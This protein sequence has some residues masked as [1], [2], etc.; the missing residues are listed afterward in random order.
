M[1]SRQK[2]KKL[3]RKRKTKWIKRFLI[4]A[5]LSLSLI[6]G[7]VFFQYQKGVKQAGGA[8]ISTEEVAEFNGIKDEQGR[9]N[10]LLLG[11]DTRGEEKSRTDTIM[12]AQYDPKNEK[13]RLVSLMRDI[14][15]DIP[16]HDSW[17][18]NT[19]NYLGGPEL[20]RQTIKENFDIDVQYYALV[21]FTGFQTAVDIIAPDGIEMDVEKP[22]SKN[23]GV[24]LEPGLQKLNGEELLG[25]ARFR[26]DALGDFG[27][28]ERQQKVVTALKDEVLSLNSIIKI[29]EL[30][31][32][33][34]PY[35]QTNMGIKDRVGL[36]TQFLLNPAET[37]ETLK[38][39][40]DGSYEDK[41]Y[42]RAG[43]VLEIDF[44][45][46]RSAL[47][48]FLNGEQPNEMTNDSL[49]TDQENEN[50]STIE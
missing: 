16:D 37:I 50:A 29:P 21:D 11:I 43:A 33:L 34:T 1:I 46:N 27:R 3:K 28:V 24:Q 12:I 39:P 15:V 31:G 2:Y 13:A 47:K 5:L 19:A 36:A 20:L 17:K 49:D 38:I 45:E 22:M 23:I 18:L 35:I 44:E 25:Y 42:E 10:V 48:S 40:I 26:Q 30:L 8:N 41:R 7:Y 4:G 9:I 32:A 6:A 14:Y